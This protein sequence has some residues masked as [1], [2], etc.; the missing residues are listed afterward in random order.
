M[1]YQGCFNKSEVWEIKLRN[2]V[3]GG[4]KIFLVLLIVEKGTCSSLCQILNLFFHP[5]C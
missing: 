1:I 4:L 2:V 3:C 5:F